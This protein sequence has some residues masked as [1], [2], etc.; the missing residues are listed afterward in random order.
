MSENVPVVGEQL[1]KSKSEWDMRKLA[2]C[3]GCLTIQI[4]VSREHEEGSTERY[5]TGIDG[6]H[7]ASIITLKQWVNL[8][9]IEG[10]QE[11]QKH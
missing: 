4:D 6:M 8:D 7:R 9:G 5:F 11:I 3:I 1:K 2:K 10:V